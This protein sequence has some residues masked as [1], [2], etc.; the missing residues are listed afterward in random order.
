MVSKYD[1]E[2]DLA[3]APETS[4]AKMVELVGANKRVLDVGCSTGYLARVL[5]ALG[6]TVSGV[7]YDAAAAKEPE[8]DLAKLVVGDLERLDLVAEFG[9]GSF[10]VVVFGDVLEHLRDPMPV[11][12]QARPLLAAGGSVVIS[13][14]NIA[15]GD[16]RLALLKGRFRY[17]KL[18]LLDETHTRFF[19]RENLDSFVREAGF[20]PVDV[21]RTY[22]PLFSTEVG[23]REDEV[24]PAVA[25]ELRTD[26][27][28]ETY[29]FVLRAVR[30]D[31]VHV[32]VGLTD[33]AE[34]LELKV[35]ELSGELDRALAAVDV[36]TEAERAA[37]AAADAARLEAAERAERAEREARQA[38]AEAARLRTELDEVYRT[39]VMRAARLPRAIYGALRR[40]RG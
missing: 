27:E 10:D 28:A 18:G 3:A 13:V 17:T 1:V 21:R 8:P 39:R 26:P 5:G 14:P 31:A 15:H 34:K 2:V 23:V 11:L 6:N 35:R 29:Q 38:A 36:A 12:R 32:E 16:V 19:T 4:H 40:H 22:A 37:A 9:E 24:D 20:V 25:A 33:R 30:D 7:E